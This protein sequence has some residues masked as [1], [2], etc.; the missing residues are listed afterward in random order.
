ML[1]KSSDQCS[2]PDNYDSGFNYIPGNYFIIESEIIKASDSE[3]G[4]DDKNAKTGGVQTFNVEPYLIS[5]EQTAKK[6]QRPASLQNMLAGLL[7]VY[8]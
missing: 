3:N 8:F 1:S 6:E 4:T 2:V 7:L 5:R